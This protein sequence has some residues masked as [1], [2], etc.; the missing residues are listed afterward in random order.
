M[1]KRHITYQSQKNRHV[2]KP[3]PFQ[4][5]KFRM[6]KF[7]MPKGMPKPIKY[8]ASFAISTKKPIFT[9]T[10][11]TNFYNP[12]E[13]PKRQ[14]LEYSGWQPIGFNYHS[15][16]APVEAKVEPEIITI[17]NAYRHPKKYEVPALPTGTYAPEP[18]TAKPA[19][20]EKP[21]E[22]VYGVPEVAIETPKTTYYNPETPKVK[23]SI[24]PQQS[25]EESTTNANS[26]VIKELPKKY[27]YEI[28]KELPKATYPSQEPPAPIEEPLFN[29]APVQDLTSLAGVGEYE[30]PQPVY[31]GYSQVNPGSY[32]AT[33]NSNHLAQEVQSGSVYVQQKESLESDL[34]ED[35]DLYFI[36]YDKNKTNN[37]RK[38]TPSPGSASTA[39]FSI[40]VNGQPHGFSHNLDH[41]DHRRGLPYK[42]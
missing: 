3:A 21:E 27:G 18:I 23:K 7:R 41:F 38:V 20:Y 29:S 37:K 33:H 31:S 9:K 40:Q 16:N 15:P 10:V 22:V 17:D 25:K 28:I 34:E 32:Q 36:F 5:P 6:P 13:K 1:G 11:K 19:Q 42:S 12:T 24:F 35:E 2:R 26:L 30:T 14:K 39:S 4:V 8:P